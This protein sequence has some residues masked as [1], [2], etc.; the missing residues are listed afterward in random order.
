MF[1]LGVFLQLTYAPHN[2][3]LHALTAHAIP[4][5]THRMVSHTGRRVPFLSMRWI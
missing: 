2:T 5:Y 1:L 3:Q 4:E